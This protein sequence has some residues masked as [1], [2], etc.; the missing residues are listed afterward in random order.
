M[1]EKR[2]TYRVKIFV[3]NRKGEDSLE[4]IDVYVRITLMRIL[5]KYDGMVL[6]AS[7]TLSSEM[8]LKKGQFFNP[9]AV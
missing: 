8:N 7:M 4:N 1:G 5:K 9:F 6:F 2:N 3:G